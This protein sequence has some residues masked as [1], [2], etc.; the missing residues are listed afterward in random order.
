M[1]VGA[2]S[3]P[4]YRP[5]RS[6]QSPWL[7]E[8]CLMHTNIPLVDSRPPPHRAHQ[9]AHLAVEGGGAGWPGGAARPLRAGL[10][11]PASGRSASLASVLRCK[12]GLA[13]AGLD[14]P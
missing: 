8:I 11:P 5:V 7:G 1:D 6:Q 13:K 4:A 12:L 10:Q 3:I 14:L 2:G 9:R